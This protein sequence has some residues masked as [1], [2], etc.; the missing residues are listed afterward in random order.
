MPW[1]GFRTIWHT[2]KWIF[3]HSL[4]SAFFSIKQQ[5]KKL[6][7]KKKQNRNQNTTLWCWTTTPE[8]CF[9]T[10][11]WASFSGALLRARTVRFWQR[12]TRDTWL[13]ERQLGRRH[14]P[15]YEMEATLVVRTISVESFTL[16]NNTNNHNSLYTNIYIYIQTYIYKHNIYIYIQYI[17]SYS[18]RYLY[19]VGWAMKHVNC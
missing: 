6:G 15:W 1:C 2:L 7:C 16:A 8:Q 17:Y 5:K 19:F 4:P 12:W 18:S 13:S 10:L 3:F 14:V 9:Q 11:P